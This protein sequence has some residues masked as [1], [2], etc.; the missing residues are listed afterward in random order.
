M[1]MNIYIRSAACIA[2]TTTLGAADL[3]PMAKPAEDLPNAGPGGG[4]LLAKPAGNR[5]ACLEPDYKGLID[6]KALRRMSRIIRMGVATAMDCLRQAGMAMPDAIV[7]GTGYGCL[8]DTG[9]FLTNMITRKEE[10]LQPAT[11]IQSTHNTVGAQI[12]LVLQCTGYNNTF[13]HRGFSFENAVLD[14]I[15]LLQEGEA[16]TVLAGGVDELTDASFAILS[17]FGSYRHVPAGEGSAFFV[18]AGQPTANDYAKLEGMATFYKPESREEIAREIGRFLQE[19][20]V[21][22]ASIDLVIGDE[23][24]PGIPT[25]TYKTQCGEYPTSTAYAVWLAARLIKR[26]A[27]KRILVYNHY[28]GIYHAAFLLA[29]V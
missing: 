8:E 1:T 16:R 23:I 19:Q 17:R 10:A 21:D 18:L 26:G 4:T 25:Q 15:L 29:A 20:A 14:A 6:P 7:T 12:A 5:L 9:V 13:V 22:P 2:P 28:L 11:F 3:P 24:L 27:C